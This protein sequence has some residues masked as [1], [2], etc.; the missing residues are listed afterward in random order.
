MDIIGKAF[1]PTEGNARAT[2]IELDNM[3]IGLITKGD[4][5]Q[6]TIALFHK[7][8]ANLD[9]DVFNK[10][11]EIW[12]HIE[13]ESP[14]MMFCRKR[15]SNDYGLWGDAYYKNIDYVMG[16]YPN[17][18]YALDSS[19]TG[20]YADLLLNNPELTYPAD[21]LQADK[22]N[23]YFGKDVIVLSTAPY[24]RKKDLEKLEKA[25]VD[26]VKHLCEDQPEEHWN[27]AEKVLRNYFGTDEA[28]VI[29]VNADDCRK[30]VHWNISEGEPTEHRLKIEW[31]KVGWELTGP[32]WNEHTT[33]II[34]AK[35]GSLVYEDFL[36]L[37]ISKITDTKITLLY[38]TQQYQLAPGKSLKFFN[39]DSYENSEG[40][41][42]RDI[43]Y[44]LN[45]T[46]LSNEEK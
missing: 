27:E 3:V 36:G 1:N 2:C 31:S 24:N 30:R 40:I 21:F 33:D 42:Y 34:Q 8:V 39:N 5:A 19:M 23:F 15:G 28:F 18:P 12:K 17:N 9:S 26:A 13:T 25:V 22:F 44:E 20:L 14:V 29:I 4:D 16:E 46:W 10:G 11:K 43:N 6:H 38:G 7:V 35:T 45:I 37:C 32:E 41:E